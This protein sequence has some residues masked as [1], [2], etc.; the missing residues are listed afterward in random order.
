MEETKE[1]QNSQANHLT[2]EKQLEEFCSKGNL[3]LKLTRTHLFPLIE[4]EPSQLSYPVKFAF[5]QFP[6]V[7]GECRPFL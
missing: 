7:V 4:T 5:V 3:N 6:L 1:L 2:R